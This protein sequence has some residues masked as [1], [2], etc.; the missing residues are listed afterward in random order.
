M[1]VMKDIGILLVNLG[2]PDSPRP[3]DVKQYLHEFLTDGRVID[4]PWPVR[5]VLTRGLIVP[6]RYKESAQNYQEIWTDQ[7]SPLI[8]YGQSIALKLQEKL[9]DDFQVG[10]AMRYRHPSIESVLNTMKRCSQIIILPLFPQYASATT[11]S[12]H[13]KVMGIVKAWQT[14]PS[15]SFVNSFPTEPKMITAFCTL[16]REHAISSYDH[17]LLSFH[18]L[19]KQQLE[20]SDL[21]NIC[22][23]AKDCCKKLCKKNASCYSAQCHATASAIATEL[24]LDPNKHSISFQSR[25]GKDPWVQPY[26]SEVLKELV[27]K[28]CKKVLVICPAFV[29]D[30]VETIHEISVEY[31]KEFIASGGEKLELVTGLNDHPLWINALQDIVER[32]VA[33]NPVAVIERV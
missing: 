28:G 20:K 27:E 3:K 19:P 1:I 29:C 21:N 9:G 22:L 25:L 17:V 15:L 32:Y 11:G 12:V 5:Q 33:I 18:G 4:V 8:V 30:C 31:Q 13:Q 10:L 23:K 2:T 24:S 14:I 16:A 6:R 7:G 26:T